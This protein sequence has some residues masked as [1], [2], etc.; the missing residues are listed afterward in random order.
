MQNIQIKETR[1]IPGEAI[2]ALYRANHWSSADK[3]EQLL[4][5]LANSHRLIS[6]WDG[7]QLVGLGNAISDGHLV[8]YFPHLV[9]LPDYQGRGIGRMIMDRMAVH[10]GDF[11]QQQLV[12]DGGSVTFY[13]KCGFRR[14]GDTVPMWIYGGN[15]H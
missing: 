3:P 12:A 1:S 7:D 13:E 10:Y 8:V 9:V 5:A 6:A 2:L 11:H 15:E 4:P 14:S